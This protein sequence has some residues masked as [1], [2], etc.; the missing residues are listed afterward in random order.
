VAEVVVIGPSQ[1]I[2]GV[3]VTPEQMGGVASRSTS[4]GSNRSARSAAD[5]WSYAARHCCRSN[6]PRPRATASDA[7]IGSPSEVRPAVYI[8]R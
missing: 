2:G 1:Q 7:V 4:S 6:D 3:S 5:S 8:E